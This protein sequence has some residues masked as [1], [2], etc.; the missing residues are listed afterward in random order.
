MSIKKIENVSLYVLF[1]KYRAPEHARIVWI[2]I[3][4]GS[5]GLAPLD[6]QHCS[7]EVS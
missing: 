4:H 1:L 6:P 2:R 3:G 5:V 7:K